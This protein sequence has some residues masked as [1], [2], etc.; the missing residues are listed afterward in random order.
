MVTGLQNLPRDLLTKSDRDF[1]FLSNF[2]RRLSKR[3]RGDKC[4]VTLFFGKRLMFI[5]V[6][7]HEVFVFAD[8]DVALNVIKNLLSMYPTITLKVHTTMTNSSICT[9]EKFFRLFRM[10]LHVRILQYSLFPKIGL[11]YIC[12]F[13]IFSRHGEQKSNEIE[14]GDHFCS[15]GPTRIV[16]RPVTVTLFFGK[17]LRTIVQFFRLS[18]PSI[19]NSCQIFAI[20]LSMERGKSPCRPPLKC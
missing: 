4:T 10:I 14:N 8:P 16:L 6:F 13:E 1:R 2:L 12:L 19:P 15:K 11:P 3:S 9:K 20:F 7:Q 17:E 18:R 5:A